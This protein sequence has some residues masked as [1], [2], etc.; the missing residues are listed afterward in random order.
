MISPKKS[1]ILFPVLVALNFVLVRSAPNMSQIP[2]SQVV[3]PL[4]VIGIVAALLTALLQWWIKNPLRAG[5]LAS[6]CLYFFLYYASL[7]SFI[8]KLPWTT[9]EWLRGLIIL[10]TGATVAV[11]ASRPALWQRLKNP[12]AVVNF[13]NI[14]LLVLMLLPAG[15]IGYYLVVSSGNL[16]T[17]QEQ[18]TALPDL[19]PGAETARPDI[20][21]IILD[22]YS[23]EDVLAELFDFDNAETVAFLEN[24][25]FY[26]ART[27]RSNY[28]QTLLSVNSALNLDYLNEWVAPLSQTSN[29]WPMMQLIR[30]SRAQAILES[31][32]YTVISVSSVFQTDLV[33]ADLRFSLYGDSVLNEF[34]RYLLAQTAVRW[35]A[36][37]FDLDIPRPGFDSH[38]ASIFYVFE[39][40]SQIP[41]TVP[42]PK[43]V[44]AHILGPHPP[45]VLDRNGAPLTPD[46]AYTIGDGSDYPGTPDDYR[47]GYSDE[48]F[49]IN[50]LLRKMVDDILTHSATPPI[51]ILQGDH[52]SGMFLDFSSPEKSCAR[53]RFSI[54]NAYYLPGVDMSRLYDDISPV[55]SFRLIMN[56]YFG[57]NLELLEEKSYFSTWERPYAFIDVTDRTAVP[58]LAP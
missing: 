28:I 14:M 58:C 8:G 52:G 16:K 25:G 49:Y 34:E 46:Y 3:R 7:S 18:Q 22:G 47:R 48:L 12:T 57:A 37:V 32:D 19:H 6:C 35:I 9:P 43:F 36:E 11:L 31:L 55:N 1:Y 53:E 38:R 21:Y 56:A 10:I 2:P 13:L 42:G 17:I 44:F 51:I 26:V 23:R 45:F 30:N 24:R 20:Y 54:L 40:L 41:E 29:R 33:N 39:Q 27:A 50:I 5:V 15:A 4:I